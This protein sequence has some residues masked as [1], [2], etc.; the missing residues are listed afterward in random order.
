MASLTSSLTVKLIDDVT[1]P[2]KSVAQALQQAQKQAEAVAKQLANSGATDRFAASLSKLKLSAKDIDTVSRAWKEYSSSAKLAGNASEWTKT[3]AAGVKRWES[4][5]ISALR[6]VQREQAAFARSSKKNG[7]GAEGRG[8]AAGIVG[9][10]IAHSTAHFAKESLE[11]YREFDKE[12]RFGKAVMGIS[13]S[14]QSPLVAQAIHMGATSRYNDI[15]VLEAQRELA[16]RGLNKESILGMIPAAANLGQSLDLSLPDAAKQMEG[17]FFGFKKD[18]SSVEAAAASAR[19]TADIQVKAA[20]ISGM[21]PEDLLQVY[22]FG[23]TPAR[24]SGVSEQMLLAFGG[25]SKK[26]N[27]GGDEAGTAFRALM[28][29]A[30]SPTYG[31]KTALLANGLDYSKYQSKI[32]ALDVDPFAKNVAAQYGVVLSKKATAGLKQVFSDPK[33]L[34]DAALFTP[35]VTK[36]LTGQLHGKDAKSLK[37]IATMANRY[38]NSAGGGADVNAFLADLM[39]KLPGNIKLANAIFGSKQ[40]ARIANALGDPE[41]MR[42]MIEQLTNHSDGYAEKIAGERMEGFDGAVSRFEGATKNLET[43]IG[44]AFDESKDGKSGFVTQFTNT[45]GQFVQALA[46]APPALVRLTTE[47]GAA[48]A[49]FAGLKGLEALLGGFG[50]TGL[51]STAAGAS[52][53]VPP[54]AAAAGLTYTMKDFA[55]RMP[56]QKEQE[57]YPNAG[58]ELPGLEGGLP[59]DPSSG[60][61][62]GVA[63]QAD[64]AKAALQSVNDVK[65]APVV[66]GS[67]LDAAI[68]KANQLA[69][70]LSSLSGLARGV[71]SAVS[72]I[73]VPALGPAQR[74]NFSYGGVKGE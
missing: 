53:L 72:G 74:G 5:T 60:S 14:D 37:S 43:A 62:A 30:Q 42:A 54:V 23:A 59:N 57:E 40:G 68:A 2:A 17:A 18:L 73:N 47:A 3:Q 13:D 45:A 19:Q 63:K 48:A 32:G 33:L 34:N 22:K 21:T 49:A 56:T 36:L 41:T 12:R 27:I 25:I 6:A 38:R 66:D 64:N 44:R 71:G 52:T 35:A 7:E 9:G 58:L 55:S 31:A 1:K 65:V 8:L 28:A 16:A 20:K 46:E 67:S 70:T 39:M 10:Y 26:A 15:A 61:V 51:A 24:M 29:A 50:L 11:T 69:A 4:Q